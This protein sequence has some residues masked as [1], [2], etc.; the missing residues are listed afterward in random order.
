MSGH[1]INPW[2]FDLL[3]AMDRKWMKVYSD[4]NKSDQ[5]SNIKSTTPQQ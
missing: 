4:L 1:R 2:E 5:T 3:R